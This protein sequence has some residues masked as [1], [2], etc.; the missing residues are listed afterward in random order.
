MTAVSQRAR[1]ELDDLV[2]RVWRH[3]DLPGVVA[4]TF[5]SGQIVWQTRRGETA[6]RYRIGSVTKTFTAAGVM[7]LRDGGRLRLD[8]P[9]GAYLP[10]APRAGLTIRQLLAHSSGLT[11]EPAGPWWERSPGGDWPAL[12]EA[13]ASAPDVF[14]PGTRYHYSNLGYA[15]LG[16]LVVRVH[17][18]SWFEAVRLDLLAPLGLDQTSYGPPPGAAVGTSRDSRTGRLVREP[19]HDS[20]AMAP[21]G[22][23]WS[24][25]TDLAAWADFLVCGREG[26]LSA[27]T[28]LEMRTAQSAD[29][30]TQH[31]GAYGLGL[32]LDWTPDGTLVGH[33]GS[34]PGFVCGLFV[35]PGT[36]VGSVVLT[37]A[38]TGLG[39][40]SL[41][42]DLIRIA[43][44][45]LTREQAATADPPLPASTELA[46]K[47][48]WGNTAVSLRATGDGFCLTVQD[49]PRRFVVEGPDRYRGVSGYFAGERLSVVRRTDGTV[50]HLTVVTFILTRLPYDARAPIPGGPPPPDSSRWP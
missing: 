38:T 6:D 12:V 50:S 23:L 34:M 10:D 42:A 46:G 17:G 41:F 22:Q 20:G 37:N 19:A 18:T 49:D 45:G 29:P 48:Y 33:A 3:G 13:N 24:S 7:R 31:R 47:W 26:V 1:D 36:R 8:E 16:E 9:I 2:T 27:E 44:S 39:P 15:L 32:R 43:G 28:L 40:A 4:A 30:D 14:A 25:V 11:A 5:A 21:A 35:D